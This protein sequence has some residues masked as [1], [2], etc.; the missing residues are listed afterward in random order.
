MIDA[1]CS[2][3]FYNSGLASGAGRSVTV[4]TGGKGCYTADDAE[5]FHSLDTTLAESVGQVIWTGTEFMIWGVNRV[6]RS[7]DGAAWSSTATKL[8]PAG[9]FRPEAVAKAQA[10]AYV[11]A[12]GQYED[13]AFYRSSDGVAWERL[14]ASPK[15]HPIRKIVAGYAPADLACKP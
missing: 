4:G 1:D 7:S 2:F 8:T 12:I 11:A 10:G 13:Q 14:A 9:T 3:D 15:G 6:A 5:T